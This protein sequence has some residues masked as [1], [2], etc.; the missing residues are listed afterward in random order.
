MNNQC[1]GLPWL[2]NEYQIFFCIREFET[3][4]LRL[5]EASRASNPRNLSEFL[6]WHLSLKPGSLSVFQLLCIREF[7]IQALRLTEASRAS[8]PRILSEFLGRLLSL[9][10]GSPS[11]FQLPAFDGRTTLLEVKPRYLS[12][13]LV[14][15]L[16][17]CSFCC[18]LQQTKPFTSR[19]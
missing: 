8:N 16:L 13:F 5:T 14:W 9:K 18:K 7:E 10:P 11:V 17:T 6:G 3:Q 4:A 2:N 19:V 12:E 1:S 15:V